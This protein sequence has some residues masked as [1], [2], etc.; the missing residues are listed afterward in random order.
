MKAVKYFNL[1]P[2]DEFK[3]T[4]HGYD[5][6][7]FRREEEGATTILDKDGKPCRHDYKIYPPMVAVVWVED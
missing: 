7:V 3:L 2:G 1:N 5:K 6:R 4:R